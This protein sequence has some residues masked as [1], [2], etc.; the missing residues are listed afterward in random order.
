MTD[1][2]SSRKEAKFYEDSR[3]D[4]QDAINSLVSDRSPNTWYTIFKKLVA[5][6]HAYMNQPTQ[7]HEFAFHHM[8]L[9]CGSRWLITFCEFKEV[10]YSIIAHQNLV[11][12]KNQM[13]MVSLPDLWE[14][15]L[16]IS[17]R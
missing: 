10:R 7:W 5:G 2:Y 3:K 12:V 4:I 13:L 1:V 8:S 15:A 16:I 17:N 9:L 14:R 11:G 6:L